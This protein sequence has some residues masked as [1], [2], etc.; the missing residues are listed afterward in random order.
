[1]RFIHSDGGRS[2]YYTA[3]NVGDCATRA[4][5]NATGIDY[6]RVYKALSKL[7]GKPVRNGCPKKADK[8]LLETIGWEWHACMSI[9]SGCTTHLTESELPNETMVVA[10]SGHLTCVK[11]G[12]I[13]DTYDCSRDESRCVYG[14]WTKPSKVTQKSMEKAIDAIIE[15]KKPQPKKAKPKPAKNSEY[16]EI[17]KFI[18]DLHKEAIKQTMM[19]GGDQSQ[20]GFIRAATKASVTEAI[21]KRMGVAVAKPQIA[22]PKPAKKYV[23]GWDE[24]GFTEWETYRTYATIKE[25]MREAK[26]HHQG[27]ID[28]QNEEMGGVEYSSI[29][30]YI[31]KYD[32]DPRDAETVMSI[33]GRWEIYEWE[34]EKE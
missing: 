20:N 6:K 27:E 31:G 5:A 32:K 22:K 30:T 28:F 24:G 1:M 23:I 21:L 11:D 18:Y 2:K 16:E 34:E 8:K 19:Y 4:I 3:T 14:Y 26:K 10:V 29:R 15:G 7:A 13:L 9:G 33:E 25:A 17:K 12:A